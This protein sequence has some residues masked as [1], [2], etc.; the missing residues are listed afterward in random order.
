MLLSMMYMYYTLFCDTLK[1]KKHNDYWKQYQ[2]IGHDIVCSRQRI[3]LVLIQFTF[4]SILTTVIFVSVY[5][6]ANCDMKYNIESIMLYPSFMSSI[7]SPLI[8]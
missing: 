8:S 6:T 5:L 2:V 1:K 3:F 7:D 4:V